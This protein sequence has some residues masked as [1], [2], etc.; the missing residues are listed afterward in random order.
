M[1]NP[2]PRPPKSSRPVI[3]PVVAV[4]DFEN[5][6]NF[7]GKWNLGSG[8]ADVLTQ[9]L[10]SSDRV[11]VLERRHMDSVLGEISRQGR[12]LFRRAW[13]VERGRL[14]NARYL[15]RGSVTDFTVS[16]DAS[17]WFAAPG[18]RGFLRG[19]RARVSLY[20]T[21][22]DVETGEIISSVRS[23]GSA[24]SG[25][26]GASL[27]YRKISFGGDVYFRTPLGRATEM[28]MRRA[29]ARILRDLPTQ[30]WEPR[31]AEGGPETVIINGGENVRL[32]IGEQ[33]VVREEGR[34]V[35]DPITGHVI[36]T[37]PGRVIGRIQV[38]IVNP[39]SAHAVILEGRAGRGDFLEPVVR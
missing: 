9:Q 12:D 25:G 16:G 31:V 21:V 14:M 15:I 8:M 17:G 28:A 38:Q 13:R 29:V 34:S 39:A 11:T 19:S 33:F 36:D 10:L 18:G 2:S 6:A 1:Y 20:V 30:Y 27:D 5:Q 35:T 32:K 4:T 3:K 23:E 7:A 26:M 37:I 24:T 22:S